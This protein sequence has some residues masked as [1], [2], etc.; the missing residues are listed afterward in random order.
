MGIASGAM[1]EVQ[2]ADTWGS[3]IGLSMGEVSDCYSRV[4]LTSSSTIYSPDAFGG[5]LGSVEGG[6]VSYCYYAGANPANK[7][8]VGKV[9]GGTVGSSV[10]FVG[11][12]VDDAN[13]TAL[14][15]AQLASWGA[16]YQL[17]EPLNADSTQKALGDLKTWRKAGG[18]SENGGYPVL[19]KEGDSITSMQSAS[20]WG[21]VGAWVDAF[22]TDDAAVKG[23]PVRPQENPAHIWS[24]G[25][26]SAAFELSSPEDIAWLAYKVNTANAE[27][28]SKNAVLADNVDLFGG[29]YTGKTF[30]EAADL[31]SELGTKALC[32]VAMGQT[33]NYAGTF[34][35]QGKKVRHLYSPAT[36]SKAGLIG[37]LTGTV[38]NVAVEASSVS[39]PGGANDAAG[40]V[41]ASITGAATIE[42]CSAG[43]DVSVSAG[44]AG[45]IVGYISYGGTVLDCASR[46][47]VTGAQ[48]GGIMGYAY[49]AT[50][51]NSYFAG[52][53]AGAMVCVSEGSSTFSDN[54]YQD[55]SA[56][57]A[58]QIA[59][60]ATKLSA[61]EMTVNKGSSLA[62]KLN[63]GRK[64]KDAPWR[65]DSKGVNDA[66][67]VLL[68]PA[69]IMADWGEVGAR[70][71]EDELRRTEVLDVDGFGTMGAVHDARPSGGSYVAAL[72][73]SGTEA[74]PYIFR[75]PEAFA[76]WGYMVNEHG[77][78]LT[79][80]EDGTETTMTFGTSHAK[81]GAD[82]DL[83]GFMYAG[84]DTVGAN[85][86]NCLMWDPIS[87]YDSVSGSEIMYFGSFD[88]AGYR[89]EN[90]RLVAMPDG[91][92]GLF[93]DP[94]DGTIKRVT[95]SSGTLDVANME[96]YDDAGSI[97]GLSASI[98]LRDCVSLVDV[99]GVPSVFRTIGGVIGYPYDSTVEN[100]YYGGTIASGVPAKPVVGTLD[101]MS[102]ANLF[103]LDGG[104]DDPSA[105]GLTADQLASWGA[106]YQLNAPLSADGTQKAF[107]DLKTWRMAADGENN[108]FP[109]PCKDG[110]SLGAAS[111]WG[112][113]GAWVDAFG[114]D[115]AADKAHP[116]RPQEKADHTWQDTTMGAA[117][118]LS[119]PEQLA[120]FAYKTNSDNAFMSKN[121]AI[122]AD[123][124]L[125]GFEYTG[126][127]DIEANNK[128]VGCLTW[129][130][131]GATAEPDKGF[132]AHFDGG[133]FLV[134]D[135]RIVDDSNTMNLGFFGHTTR[136]HIERVGLASGA[137]VLNANTSGTL[138]ASVQDFQNPDPWESV[139]G[140]AEDCFSRVDVYGSAAA[141]DHSEQAGL[142]GNLCNSN[143]RNCYYAGTVEAG[144]TLRYTVAL[145]EDGEM[146]NVLFAGRSDA[147]DLVGDPIP[148]D[149]LAGWGG[150]YQLNAPLYKDAD[151]VQ[152]QKPFADLGTWREDVENVN[153]GYPVL[154][155]DADSDSLAHLRAAADWG[156]VGAWVDTFVSTADYFPQNDD[157]VK[158]E[159]PA[160]IDVPA[161]WGAPT[162]TKAYAI[163]TPEDLAWFFGKFCSSTT[164]NALVTKP[165]DLAGNA[166]TG[167]SGTGTNFDACLEWSSGYV[168]GSV[169]D[170]GGEPI[171]NLY[172]RK[173][174][175]GFFAMVRESATVR[176]VALESGMFN[177]VSASGPVG[178][179]ASFV[180]SS[181]VQN[182]FSRMDLKNDDTYIPAGGFVGYMSDS[183]VEGSYF[184]GNIAGNV[185]SCFQEFSNST[186]TL[187]T[188]QTVTDTAGVSKVT[189]AE[190]QS[191]RGVYHL[192]GDKYVGKPNADGSALAHTV[193]TVDDAATPVNDGYPV[194]GDLT[195]V[196]QDITLDPA[197]A[198]D[199]NDGTVS[200]TLPT[201]LVGTVFLL[202]SP[203]VSGLGDPAAGGATLVAAADVKAGFASWGTD[204]ANSKLG[205][206]AGTTGITAVSKADDVLST[207]GMT[208]IS[209]NAAAASTA[210]WSAPFHSLR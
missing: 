38:R 23:H 196:E 178:T 174:T 109:V 75:T 210:L 118:E 65:G 102:L 112:D 123:I 28:G 53:A 199:S 50:I 139:P 34:D 18:D 184:A 51:K 69:D 193:W 153:G 86:E 36:A 154:V 22:G 162:G 150:A 205:L 111:N 52:S 131:I 156:E 181:T 191:W 44:K 100:C 159:K 3:L 172:Q 8:C 47:T 6:S 161:S 114:T 107:G 7:R 207:T 85:H 167:K 9:D 37:S 16:A 74:D 91:V 4:D 43:K 54:Y 169:F 113:V 166:Y 149:Q 87:Y 78:D 104:I 190:L 195:V 160:E 194:F 106:A 82:F 58:S 145:W 108:G 133:G 72:E 157:G 192:N 164:P 17:N 99:V 122:T 117:F 5:L 10:Y 135:I 2:F 31:K 209:L 155:R 24:D 200:A 126:K 202:E 125:A 124:D 197:K 143:M 71:S 119:S 46:A 148:A 132:S 45:G 101:A 116:L 76:W 27:F 30:D 21:D 26:T 1:A 206:T 81:Q 25:S 14:A 186:G 90:L 128:Y 49:S 134:R 201:A 198:I 88:G 171:T 77:S 129:V 55:G 182:C 61:A 152:R 29:V 103:Y 68:L 15:H 80:D 136:A 98:T 41:V 183:H 11:E 130:P 142:I 168:S 70:Q 83:S 73:G 180:S 35:G 163:E 176:N 57:N 170:G 66:Y 105:T 115:D 94:N 175:R 138:A 121:A 110:E 48:A 144:L 59:N 208:T 179:L 165:L 187:Y 120:W 92:T 97:V 12:T 42:R 158:P 93:G 95:L 127:S 19:I 60:S 84:T 89:I 151:G 13:A 63:A 79:H 62:S 147:D 204:S 56:T 173:A 67:P 32:W 203:D 96:S 40:A 39:A 20:N 189:T 64:G 33:T 185:S 140:L 141:T 137:M 188:D 177:I 146:V